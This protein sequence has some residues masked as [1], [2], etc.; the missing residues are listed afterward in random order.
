MTP[1]LEKEALYLP[2][3][4]LTWLKEKSRQYAVHEKLKVVILFSGDIGFYSGWSKVRI[5]LQE[6]L[7]KGI[8]HGTLQSIPGISSIQM[9]AAA[10]GV[11]WENAGIYSIHGKTDTDG[12][13]AEVIH[14]LHENGRLF[15]LVSG[16]EDIRKL[17]ALF[18]D[19]EACRITVGYQLSYPQQKLWCLHR[20]RARRHNRK[21][22]ML[23]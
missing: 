3:K 21:D 19:K 20:K 16:A 10:C 18:S 5:C 2:D 17:G 9:M 8:L 13:Q 11:S 6:A 4:I 12:W 14:R 22:C 7:Q 1:K 23:S 15:L